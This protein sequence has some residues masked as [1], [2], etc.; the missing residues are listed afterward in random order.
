MV[1]MSEVRDFRK[2]DGLN[3]YS[4]MFAGFSPLLIRVAGTLLCVVCVNGKKDIHEIKHFLKIEI[5]FNMD[6]V[7]VSFS[8]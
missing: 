4:P 2:S 7:F 5:L 8:G 6:L 3:R 1:S